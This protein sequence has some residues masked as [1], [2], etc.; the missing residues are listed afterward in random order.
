MAAMTTISAAGG[1]ASTAISTG[2]SF[3]QAAKQRKLMEQAEIDAD[4][5]MAEARGKLEINYAEQMSIKKEA[6]DLEREAMLVQGAMATQAGVE[7]ERGAAATAGRI[8]AGQQAGQAQIRGAMADEMTNIEAAILEEE[9]RLRD[10]GVGLDLEEVAG[11]Q[12]KAAQAQE[13]MQAAKAQGIQGVTNLVGQGISMVPLYQQDLAAQQ[14]AFGEA[15]RQ[16]AFGDK[17]VNYAGAERSLSDIPFEAMNRGQFRRFK[18]GAGKPALLGLQT[19][20]VYTDIYKGYMQ[21]TMLPNP[22]GTAAATSPQVNTPVQAISPLYNS[23]SGVGG[24]TNQFVNTSPMT[25][26]NPGQIG[27]SGIGPGTTRQLTALPG[28]NLSGVGGVTNPFGYL[29]PL[30]F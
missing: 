20:P 24:L 8:Y 26:I 17:T 13:A 27:V 25:G 30:Q 29:D 16:G 23:L 4:K 1:L 6:Y 3:T 18:R 15:A 10:L 7:S 22:A 11:E 9:S 21:G 2:V 19:N 28:T 5:A 14:A 12:L